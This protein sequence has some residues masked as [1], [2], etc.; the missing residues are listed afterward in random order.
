MRHGPT[1]LLREFY[2]R[3]SEKAISGVVAPC[4]RLWPQPQEDASSEHVAL[5]DEAEKLLADG[6]SIADAVGRDVG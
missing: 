3:F 2:V 5:F 6:M 1:K 4:F